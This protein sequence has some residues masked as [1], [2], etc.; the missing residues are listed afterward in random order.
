M[1]RIFFVITFTSVVLAC[2]K[3]SSDGIPQC[4]QEKIKQFVTDAKSNPPRTVI[5]S[6]YKGEKVYYINS[7][8]CDQYNNLYDS[9]CNKLCSPDG[10]FT[11]K[12]DGRCPDFHT[13]KSNEKLIWK[14][15][16]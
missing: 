15:E 6:I 8:C 4:I 2:N 10:G 1:I 14:D 11:G 13:S 3:N 5:E 7:P 16:R 12:G 9:N